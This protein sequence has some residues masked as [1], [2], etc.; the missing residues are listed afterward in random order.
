MPFARSFDLATKQQNI[1]M[2]TL[3]KSPDRKEQFKWIG[4]SYKSKAFLVGLNDR[5]DINIESLEQAKSFVVGTIRGY[6]SAK[7]LQNAGFTTQHNLHL[8]VRF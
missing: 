2:A 6:H 8:S 4:R 7:Y 5:S 3:M 1:I